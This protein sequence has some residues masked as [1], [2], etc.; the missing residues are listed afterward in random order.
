M[1]TIEQ[2]TKILSAYINRMA[3]ADLRKITAQME[4]C[5]HSAMH[6]GMSG[7]LEEHYKLQSL[8]ESAIINMIDHDLSIVTEVVLRE[9]AV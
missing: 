3:L 1:K 9:E 2:H 4:S 6:H 8:I 5:W 7:Q